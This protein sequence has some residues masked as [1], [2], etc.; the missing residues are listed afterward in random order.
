V[1][2]VDTAASSELREWAEELVARARADGID[3]TG[4][5]GL[6]TDGAHTGSVRGWEHLPVQ[7]R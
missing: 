2:V 5:G 4:E 6:L 7:T 1:T 3:L